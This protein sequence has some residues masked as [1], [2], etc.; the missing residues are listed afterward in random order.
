MDCGAIIL[1]GGQ[2]TRMGRPKA[3]LPFGPEL[4]LHRLLRRLGEVVPRRIVVAA[5]GQLLPPL[6]ADVVV[7]RDRQPGRG[8]LEGL[9]AGLQ[10]G[11][12]WAEAFYVSSCDAPLLRPDFVRALLDLL[13]PGYD[14]VVP[15]DADHYHPLSAVYHRR[16][17]PHV[18]QLLAQDQLRPF[19]LLQRVRTRE[20]P[21]EQLRAIDPSLESLRNVNR[22]EDYRAALRHAGYDTGAESS[23]EAGD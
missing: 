7:V 10:E 16:V 8:P 5:V 6:P 18:E 15:R 1:C 11:A 4:L 2:S 23:A 13:E 21:V 3:W 22:P 9:R 17:L 19:L 12:T 20:V 14:A